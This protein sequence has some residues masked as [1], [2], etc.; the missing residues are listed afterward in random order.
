MILKSMLGVA[1][2]TASLI[3]QATA[4]DSVKQCLLR[5]DVLCGYFPGHP[6]CLAEVDRCTSRCKQAASAPADQD[7]AHQSSSK[8]QRGSGG[9]NLTTTTKRC[10]DGSELITRANG[11]TACAKDIVPPTE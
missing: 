5:C 10:P 3:Y 2:W 8:G 11:T 4:A 6:E 7:S 9:K 1:L